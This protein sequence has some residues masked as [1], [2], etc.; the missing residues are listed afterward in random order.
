ERWQSPPNYCDK[1]GRCAAAARA[2]RPGVAIITLY[3]AQ[4]ELI[5]RLLQRVPALLASPVQ[6][7]V[8]TPAAFRQRE[9]FA[10]LV[11]LTRSHT[12]RA[13][14]YGEGPRELALALTRATHRVIVFGD[15]GTLS[16]RSQ[17]NGPLDHLD[18]SAA[19]RERALAARLVRV[20]QEPEP[21]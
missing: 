3:A 12:H 8:G 21:P 16:R 11:S 6:V 14:P 5:N 13:V 20:L 1:G 17:W 7:E 18:E 9:C 19:E 4:A 15:P 2:G 10:A